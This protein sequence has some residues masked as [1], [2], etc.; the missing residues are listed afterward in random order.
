VIN[1]QCYPD[2]LH[3]MEVHD[4]TKHYVNGPEAFLHTLLAEFQDAEKRFSH[5]YQKISKLVIPPS[6]LMF[7]GEL[8]DK[9]LFE[10]KYFTYSRRYFWGYQTLGV[11][12]DGIKAIIDS[13]KKTFKEDVWEGKHRTLWP[14][15]DEKASRNVHWK[16][17][18][19]KLKKSFERIITELDNLWEEMTE[20]RKEIRTLRDQLFNGT[21]VLESRKSVELSE[22]TI[23][24]GHNIKLLTLVCPPPLPGG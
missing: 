17:R 6:E 7:D 10:D 1:I 20:R 2:D 16:E 14:M 12:R 3:S 23:L 24:Q 9:L 19:V 13:Y 4:S 11:M 15:V 22:V 5:L 21:S 18:M 8:R